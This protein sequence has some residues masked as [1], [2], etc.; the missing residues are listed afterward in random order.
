MRTN[1]VQIDVY[2]H[3]HSTNFLRDV[4][5]LYHI[6]IEVWVIWILLL[7]H[8]IFWHFVW[9][10]FFFR[11]IYGWGKN[12][13]TL[14]KTKRGLCSRC[15]ANYITYRHI[16]CTFLKIKLHL[17]SVHGKEEG[18]FT[19]VTVKT[20]PEQAYG[21]DI[22]SFPVI[23]YM[24]IFFCIATHTVFIYIEDCPLHLMGTICIMTVPYI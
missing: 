22:N 20:Y 10:V 1:S 18:M 23:K 14:Q 3:Y 21:F 2:A 19:S 7:L 8:R 24:F 6:N 15:P 4:Y 11:Q 5:Y 9:I 13:L 12:A 16:Q 17:F